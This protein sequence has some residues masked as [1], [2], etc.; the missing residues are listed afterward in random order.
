MNKQ[1]KVE[2]I[3][4]QVAGPDPG[5]VVRSST[6]LRRWTAV[7][8]RLAR[9]AAIDMR[10]G[11][12]LAAVYFRN[13]DQSNSDYRELRSLFVGRLVKGDVLVDVGCGAGRVINQWLRMGFD[14]PIFG[15]EV[16]TQRAEATRRRLRRRC[17]VSI[18]TGDAV[19][20]LPSD[21]TVFFLFN[22]FDELTM[23]RF[24]KRI[25]EIADEVGNEITI[26]YL[27]CKH[28]SPFRSDP[29]FAIEE[30][31]PQHKG[32]AIGQRSAIITLSKAV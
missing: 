9:N 14:G 11:R 4:H 5:V 31:S 27:N 32:T 3:E 20:N 26:I 22:P 18:L 29:K 30:V 17:N 24:S 10:F 8:S 23:R 7:G 6:R 21:G 1:R 12:P 28:L 19:A 25:L 16:D 15:L 2:L 13:R